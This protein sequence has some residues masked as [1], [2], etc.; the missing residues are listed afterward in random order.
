LEDAKE[1]V[2]VWRQEYNSNRPHGALDNLAPKE[3]AETV[4]VVV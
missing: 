2:E 1:K 3:F 4:G